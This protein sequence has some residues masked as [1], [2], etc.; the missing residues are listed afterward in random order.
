MF[1]ISS[2]Q[3]GAIIC[4]PPWNQLNKDD[5]VL[6]GARSDTDHM[7]AGDVVKHC[8]GWYKLLPI[9]G[10]VMVRVSY[11]IY[12]V[13]KNGLVAAQFDLMWGWGGYTEHRP[14]HQVRCVSCV[15]LN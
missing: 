11:N 6:D 13:W 14:A 3:Y 12:D 5:A 9:G 2:L 10:M 1:T 8:E 15:C 4:D 7:A